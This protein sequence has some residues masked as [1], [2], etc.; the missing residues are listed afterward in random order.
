L[1]KLLSVLIPLC[2]LVIT[3]CEQSSEEPQ[4]QPNPEREE[5]LKQINDTWE[6]LGYS[7]KPTKYIALT[8]DDGPSVGTQALLDALAEQ[9]VHATF[10]VIGNNVNDNPEVLRS[11]R[12]AG[13]E[14][15]NH[16]QGYASV[17]AESPASAKRILTSCNDAIFDATNADGNPVTPRYFRAP[18]LTTGQGLFSACREMNFPLV[19]GSICNTAEAVLAA[20]GEWQIIINHDPISDAPAATAVPVYVQ[21]LRER[22][23]YIVTVRQLLVLRNVGELTP[24]KSYHDFVL[25]P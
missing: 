14:I 24:G 11:I 1:K 25:V 12:D 23:Y 3:N 8:F 21:G 5:I 7:E 13:H 4:S 22:G 18:G 2:L 15:G 20:A 9:K 10:F 6:E 16:S 17:G 19:H